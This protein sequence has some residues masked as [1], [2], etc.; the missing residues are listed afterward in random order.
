MKSSDSEYKN[1]LTRLFGLQ[2]VGIKLGLENIG[3]LCAATDDPHLKY[4]VVHIAGSNGKGSTAAF[5]AS[6]LTEAGYRTGLYTSPHLV[7]FSERI[8]VD[9]VP[10]TEDRVVDYASGLRPDIDRLRGTFFEAT[11]AMAFRYFADEQVDIAIVETGLGGRLDA[12]NIVQPVLTIITSLAIEHSEFLGYTIED[13]AR[14]KGGIIKQG[15]PLFTAVQDG[16]APDILSGICEQQ[17]SEL[18]TL[19]PSTGSCKITDIDSMTLR[20]TDDGREYVAGLAGEH[21]FSN[22]RLAIEAARL[23]SSDFPNIA[24]ENIAAGL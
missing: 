18:L 3:K 12:T 2:M 20:L 6:M 11:T 5:L 19:A 10:I 21:Q 15:V 9:G 7:D 14:E 8:R 22:A 24:D 13:I 1:T 17:G 16:E 4:P 23:L